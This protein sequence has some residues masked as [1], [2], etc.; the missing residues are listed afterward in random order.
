MWLGISWD[1]RH[2]RRGARKQ[3]IQPVY[4]LLDVCLMHVSGCLA[5][6]ERMGWPEPPRSRCHFCP[7]QGDQEWAQLT[8]EEWESACQL[9]E[10]IREK[11]PNLFLHRKAIPLRMVALKPEE[12]NLFSG[13][14]FSGMCF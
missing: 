10:M 7:N 8:P 3:W 1:E 4:P 12:G 5:A 14:C 2:R 13:G 9:D 6:V 11:D